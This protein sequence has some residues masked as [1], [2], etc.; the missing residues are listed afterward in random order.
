MHVYRSDHPCE[1][2]D[3]VLISD[4]CF[5]HGATLSRNPQVPRPS[6]SF[7]PEVY[8]DWFLMQNKKKTSLM[9]SIIVVIDG[10]QLRSESE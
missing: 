7:A 9:N 10:A 5:A 8:L 3:G 6:L 2:P 4:G 1:S